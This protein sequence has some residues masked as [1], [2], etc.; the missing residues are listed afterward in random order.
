MSIK[1]SV[2]SSLYRTLECDPNHAEPNVIKV[3]SLARASALGRE[4]W[5]LAAGQNSASAIPL[6]VREMRRDNRLN[7]GLCVKIASHALYEH[8]HPGCR[9][10]GGETEIMVEQVKVGC[11]TCAKSGV[12]RYSDTERAQAIG[13]RMNPGMSR[14]MRLAL[15]I[16]SE[17]DRATRGVV[18]AEL[19]R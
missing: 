3:A 10:C 8:M 2:L 15:D 7:A 17:H 14:L 9:T 1:E 5:H 16:I 19:E 12:H 13:E 18:S 4:L 6:L 11:P